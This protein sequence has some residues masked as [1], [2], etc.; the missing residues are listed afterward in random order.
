V[1]ASLEIELFND[2]AW[3][4]IRVRTCMLP[5]AL[6]RLFL[7][8]FKRPWV[9]EITGRNDQYRFDRTFLRPFRDYSRANSVGSRGIYLVYLLDQGKI[10]EVMEQVTW[11]RW[12]R[13]FC[14]ATELG[15][16]ERMTEKG[17]EEWLSG[18]SA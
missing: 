7:G 14:R 4:A 11:R 3:Q 8:G 2:D 6:R 17:V 10:Y 18:R 13:Y 12:D 15:E 9:A 5:E 1:K 16:I